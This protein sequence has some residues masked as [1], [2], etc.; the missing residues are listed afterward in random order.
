MFIL[1]LLFFTGGGAAIDF[2]DS[3]TYLYQYGY[4]NA[5]FSEMVMMSDNDTKY[6]T[7][8]ELYQ[9]RTYE[10]PVDGKLNNETMQ[11]MMKSRCGISDNVLQQTHP[12]KW[13]N[14]TLTSK[15]YNGNSLEIKLAEKAFDVWSKHAN[16]DFIQTTADNPNIGLSFAAGQSPVEI[17]IN[18]DERWNRNVEEEPEPDESSL[19][20]TSIHE[21]GHAMVQMLYGA[22]RSEETAP[23]PPLDSVDVKTTSTDTYPNLC[24][25]SNNIITF[26]IVNE[27]LYIFYEKWDWWKKL[28][29]DN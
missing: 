16:I 20:D 9:R 3:L 17:H 24:E 2:E 8:L 14:R 6:I 13:L 10:L 28:D 27:Q 11:L 5:E 12:Q 19:F 1:I 29:D 4:L 7:A 26:L 22:R 18:S 23:P 21:I 15:F 25:I